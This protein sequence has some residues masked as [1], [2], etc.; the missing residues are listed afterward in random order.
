MHSGMSNLTAFM[1][2]NLE[3]ISSLRRTKTLALVLLLT[4]G[5]RAPGF[6]QEIKPLYQN[7]FE[8]TTV[9]KLPDDFLVLDGAFTVQQEGANKYLELP[10]APLDSY[11]LLFGP[12][13]KEGVT[14]SARI[15]AT[16]KGRR[17]PTFALGLNGVGGYRLQVSPA[18]KLIELYRADAVKTNAPYEWTSGEWTHLRIQVRKTASGWKI[19]GKA[20]PEG[21]PEPANWLISADD[22]EE[23]PAGRAG[24]FASPFSGTPIKFDDFLVG[25]VEG[26]TAK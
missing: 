25:T 16:A 22:S 19:E 9:G 7:D 3:S 15:G 14:A 4:L 18:K 17:F 10:G 24:V 21:K 13:E 1:T 2:L 26:N 11:G 20:W 8:K 12:V 6:G 5:P 23:L